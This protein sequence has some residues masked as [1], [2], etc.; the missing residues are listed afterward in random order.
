VGVIDEIM[1]DGG[2]VGP[3]IH[4]ADVGVIGE[5]G[6]GWGRGGKRRRVGWVL[7]VLVERLW[8]LANRLR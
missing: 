8:G 3:E 2:M 7:C 6:K 5:E 4:D 1:V